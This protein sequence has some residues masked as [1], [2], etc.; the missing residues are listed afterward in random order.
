MISKKKHHQ[1]QRCSTSLLTI[2]Q[3][4]HTM[5]K[6]IKIVSKKCL[7]RFILESP[8]KCIFSLIPVSD[9]ANR[10]TKIYSL[11]K[12]L[13]EMLYN[14]K[15][16]QMKCFISNCWQNKF[17]KL[18]QIFWC[19]IV[20]FLNSQCQIVRFFSLSNKL[21]VFNSWCQIILQ[22]SGILIIMKREVQPGKYVEPS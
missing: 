2:K 20:R 21:S 10:H 19:Q 9:R 5:S 4:Y 17:S 3:A 16:Y 8:A 13:T 14:V 7:V 18:S 15:S 12:M 22:S 6:F 11:L 1:R